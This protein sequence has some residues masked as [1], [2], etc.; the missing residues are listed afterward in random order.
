MRGALI[1]ASPPMLMHSSI[2][3]TSPSASS[4][5]VSNLSINRANARSEFR[6]EVCCDRIVNT[7]S[8]MAS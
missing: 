7:T 5:K 4:S 3:C 8:L 6:S 2:T 1:F